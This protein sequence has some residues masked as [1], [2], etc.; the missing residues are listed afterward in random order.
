MQ[1]EACKARAMMQDRTQ[2]RE[3]RERWR[4][5]HIINRWVE[6]VRE[7]WSEGERREEEAVISA[8]HKHVRAREMS[9]CSGCQR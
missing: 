5:N 1:A 7:E 2:E 4:G 3:K 6:R 8:F 9:V